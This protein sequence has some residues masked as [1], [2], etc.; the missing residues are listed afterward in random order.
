ML[1][2]V[3]QN[4]CESTLNV[5]VAGSIALVM[6]LVLSTCMIWY[7]IDVNRLMIRLCIVHGL[8]L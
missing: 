1:S 8:I 3:S 6:L 5:S 7:G 4:Q 2:G